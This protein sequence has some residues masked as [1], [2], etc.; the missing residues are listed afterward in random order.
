MQQL[1]NFGCTVL[2]VHRSVWW[3]RLHLQS[4]AGCGRFVEGVQGGRCGTC[5]NCGGCAA[6]R[7]LE[8]KTIQ[9]HYKVVKHRAMH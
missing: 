1:Y 2:A 6:R 4:A 8:Q 7:S 5:H 9:I 3:L